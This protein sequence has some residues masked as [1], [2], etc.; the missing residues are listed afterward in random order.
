MRAVVIHEHGGP[1][2]LRLEDVPVPAPGPDQ[3]LIRVRACGVNRLDLMVREGRV[4]A[5]VKLPH[6]PGSEVAGELAQVGSQAAGLSEGQR[7]ALAPYLFCGQCEYCLAGEET[8]CV[9]G[10]IVGLTEDGGYAE[11]VA[12]PASNVV[13]LPDRVSYDDAAAVGL[14]ALTAWHMLVE[15]AH[16]RAGEDV[17][18]LAGG[19]GVGSAAIQIAKLSG[20]RVIA[21]AGTD[22][23]VKKSL[24][25]GADQAINYR[26]QDFLQEVRRLTGKRGVDLVVEHVGSDTWE[27]S[28]GCLARNGRL[29][30]CGTTSGTEAK[31]NLWTLF[32]KQLNLLGSYGGTRG[33]LQTVLRLVAGGRLKAVI[34][35]SLPLERAAEAHQ[36]MEHRQQ[37]GKLVL[38]P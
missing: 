23:K 13:P 34:D 8:V 11:Y 15:R 2:Q 30:I 36:L 35:R 9:K 38:N 16:V 4:G 7:V 32:A 6:I 17:L 5:K 28:V 20:A 27:K 31:L 29:A 19:S 24:E 12:A 14:A 3:V 37:F 21:T 10:N 1:D 26:E 18:V 33:E 22:E 25:L